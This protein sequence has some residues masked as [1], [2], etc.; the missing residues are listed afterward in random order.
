MNLVIEQILEAEKRAMIRGRWCPDTVVVNE[1][2]YWEVIKQRQYDLSK[3]SI[4]GMK[5]LLVPGVREA[6]AF[7][8]TLR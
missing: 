4:L 7:L 6:R 8:G 3:S 5:L 2:Q 1:E